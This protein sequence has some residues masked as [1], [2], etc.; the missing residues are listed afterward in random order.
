MVIGFVNAGLMSLSQAIGVIMGANIGTT[1]TAQL[2][3]FKISKYSLHA[4]AIGAALYLFG[5]S[6]KMKYIG[7][8]FLGFGLL[9][10]GMTTMKGVMK[11]L[12]SSPYFRELM[13]NFGQYPILGVAIG[14]FITV[15]VQSSSASIGILLSLTSVGAIPFSAA[16]PIL[17][18][19]N[20][21]TTIT[22]ILSSIGTNRTAKRA[23]WAHAL[24]NILGSAIFILMIYLIPDLTDYIASFFKNVF[25]TTDVNRLIANT[26][27]GFNILNTVLWLPFAGLLARLVTWMIPG[28]DD[29]IKKGPIHLDERFLETPALAL[30]QSVKELTHM[31]GQAIDNISD[32]LKY[33]KSG[34]QKLFKTMMEREE[35]VDELEEA[36]ILYMSKL[37]QESL[38]D[39]QAREVNN[40]FHI[41]N[42]IE[43]IGDHAENI[44]ELGEIKNDE[45]MPFSDK[46]LE[47][48]E[49]MVKRVVET[50]EMAIEAFEENDTE[51]AKKV[52][53][54]E[55]EVDELED[56]Y[57]KNHIS[58]LNDGLCYPGSGVV[59]LDI[60]SNLE[61]I[62]DHS[63]NIAKITIEGI[64]K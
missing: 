55:D 12:R 26:H 46:A 56:T 30:G 64:K 51:L 11:P 34:N 4:I 31:G 7:Q 33:F 32:S 57:R 62:G 15:A 28:E 6:K 19:G 54:F 9:F 45:K 58:R 5:R 14:T 1:I 24:F 59:Y 16:V 37:S 17:L 47:D 29:T 43:R 10:F 21:G 39:D 27:S 3:A 44:A 60:L 13:V 8:I 25:G 50:A 49:Y 61:R 48:L 38:T 2:I 23:A 35:N 63:A 22:A 18:G 52:L 40:F 41:I 42:D 20:I 53:K 36:L